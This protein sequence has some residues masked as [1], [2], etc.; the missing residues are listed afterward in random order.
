MFDYDNDPN[1]LRA[2]YIYYGA[3]HRGMEG[4][5]LSPSSKDDTQYNLA[6]ALIGS[7]DVTSVHSEAIMPT[8]NLPVS[9]YGSITRLNAG[10]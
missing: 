10:L 6:Q 7:S 3:G 1:G 4:V 9:H 8:V 2:G 5:L